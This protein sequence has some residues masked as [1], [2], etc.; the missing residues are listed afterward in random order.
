LE[1]I[2]GLWTPVPEAVLKRG[3]AL[4][5]RPPSIDRRQSNLTDE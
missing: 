5:A 1:E 2:A 3:V 4:A